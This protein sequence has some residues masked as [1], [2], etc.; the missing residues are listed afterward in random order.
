M[1]P[2]TPVD[3]ELLARQILGMPLEVTLREMTVVSLITDMAIE[4]KHLRARVKE[5]E[6]VHNKDK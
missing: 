4:I 3:L 5:L 6:D 1:T 2:P